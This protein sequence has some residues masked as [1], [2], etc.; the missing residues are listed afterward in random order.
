M[1]LAIISLLGFK[2]GW[3]TLVKTYADRS[4]SYLRVFVRESGSMNLVGMR[5]IL[6]LSVCPSGLRVGCRECSAYSVETSSYLGMQSA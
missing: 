1:W 4:E 2:A 5:S 3:Y 6:T